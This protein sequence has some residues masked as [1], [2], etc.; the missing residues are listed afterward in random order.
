MID[1]DLDAIGYS[2][3]TINY[4]K[5]FQRVLCGIYSCYSLMLKDNI[6]VPPNDENEIRNVLLDNYLNN[7]TVRNF[8]GLIWYTFNKEIPE[9][10]G[11]VD[12]KI[13]FR[14][15]FIPVK[16]YYIIE[17]K[18]LDNENLE[19]T[20]GL[21]AKYIENGIL[22]FVSKQYPTNCGINAMIGFVVK[23][24]DINFNVENNINTLLQQHF[25]SCN[26]TKYIQKETF[27]PNFEFHYSS[28]HNDI[29]NVN[30]TLYHLMLD[31][32]NNIILQ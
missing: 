16:E 20:S 14:D 5:E 25:T 27:I 15:P 3:N 26:T 17:C 19:G 1:T 2:Y 24:I 22:R 23:A 6:L 10:N 4:V 29:N 7:D 21:N 32:S 9:K 30:F 13:E 11:R 18:R 12:I 28:E 8:T 31:F